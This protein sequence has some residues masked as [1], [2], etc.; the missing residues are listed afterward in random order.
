[1]KAARPVGVATVVAIAVG[2]VW[3]L[4]LLALVGTAV[5]DGSAGAD[6]WWSAFTSP[7][8][9]TMEHVRDAT[10]ARVGGVPAWRSVV[11]TVA[12]IAVGVAAPA[13]AA[14]HGAYALTWLPVPRRGLLLSA[15]F[16]ALV[17]PLQVVVGP[18]VRWTATFGDTSTIVAL[19]LAHAAFGL[20]LALLVLR[21][22]M[23]SVPR[24][25]V[26]AARLEGATTATVLR[27]VVLPIVRPTVGAVLVWQ[28]LWIWN[29]HLVATVLLSGQD[30]VEVVATH[31]AGLSAGLGS[32]G[33]VAASALLTA[34]VPLVVMTGAHR[35]LARALPAAFLRR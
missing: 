27:R 25:A 19:A 6:G 8:S 16:V 13:V 11:T 33:V 32:D 22:A 5:S 2:I 7:T 24:S 12:V 30:D 21:D 26:E 31:L 29:D 17:L 20:P 4:P 3:S 9:L 28:A 18:I 10:F 15:L 1:M 14:V 35:V 23:D 34:L